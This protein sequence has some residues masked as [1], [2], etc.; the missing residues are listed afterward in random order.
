MAFGSPYPIAEPNCCRFLIL[1]NVLFQV[2]L[3]LVL[4]T[5][6]D[7]LTCLD[8]EHSSIECHCASGSSDRIQEVRQ[9]TVSG[10]VRAG[11]IFPECQ[12]SQHIGLKLHNGTGAFHAVQW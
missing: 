12:G 8:S 2:T 11:V 10:G 9:Q 3:H 7:E 6:F 5:K 4:F 1:R